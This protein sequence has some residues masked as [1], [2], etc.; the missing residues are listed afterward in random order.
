MLLFLAICFDTCQVLNI[1]Q[2]HHAAKNILS[3][4]VALVK[5]RASA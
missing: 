3:I 4:D 5:D 1:M 2:W